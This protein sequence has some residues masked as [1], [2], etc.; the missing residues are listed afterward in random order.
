[1][2][3]RFDRPNV[4]YQD[5]LYT[6]VKAA[7]DRKPSAA[8]DVVAMTPGWVKTDMGGSNA[9]LTP[10]QSARAIARTITPLTM[11]K[12]SLFLERTGDEVAYGW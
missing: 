4:A 2:V 6:A 12:T 3:I 9:P 8:F 7:L 10:E 11:E 1:M 5:A